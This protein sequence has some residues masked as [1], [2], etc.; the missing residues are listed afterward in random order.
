VMVTAIMTC[1][2]I[3]TPA[4]SMSRPRTLRTIENVSSPS[5]IT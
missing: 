4:N 5:R 1:Q 2:P 3:P